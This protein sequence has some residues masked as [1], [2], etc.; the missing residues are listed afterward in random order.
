MRRG[1]Q[2]P[3][4]LVRS[5]WSIPCRYERSA[6]IHFPSLRSLTRCFALP[7]LRHLMK[8]NFITS[9]KISK[10]VR[11]KLFD[12]KEPKRDIKRCN[13]RTK[14]YSVSESSLLLRSITLPTSGQQLQRLRLLRDHQI[15]QPG[16]VQMHSHSARAA[17][18]K[19]DQHSF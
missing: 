6:H 8:I 14:K 19:I 5:C 9:T 7:M 17:L 2:R 12:Q 15:V 3:S 1:R 13:M 4:G 10:F 16:F 18:S 11:K